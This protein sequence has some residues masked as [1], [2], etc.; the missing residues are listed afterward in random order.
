MD[1][2]EVPGAALEVLP[3]GARRKCMNK[4]WREHIENGQRE[5]RRRLDGELADVQRA[6]EA[7]TGG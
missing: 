3:A 1:T 4:L 2:G 5:F 6:V 7:A